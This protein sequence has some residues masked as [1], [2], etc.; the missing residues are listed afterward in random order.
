MSINDQIYFSNDLGEPLDIKEEK[1]KEKWI[2]LLQTI[3]G[4]LCIGTIT[5]VVGISLF[6]GVFGVQSYISAQKLIDQSCSI[7]N[8]PNSEKII[9]KQKIPI[10]LNYVTIYNGLITPEFFK[11]QQSIY[12]EKG[13]I[14]CIGN[15]PLTNC[16]MSP[17]RKEY[18]LKNAVITP[19]LVDIHSHFGVYSYPGDLR[20]YQD[21][22]E[23]GADPTTPYVRVI[24]A[25][26]STDEAIKEILSGGVTS[27]V[28]L[29]GSGN[30]IGGEG[31]AVKLRGK[32]VEEMRIKNS[33]RYL[34]FACGE[35][36]K[37][38]YGSQSKM[39]TTRMGN[40]W[41]M[42]KK[43]EAARKLLKEQNEWDCSKGEKPTN[44][45][46]EPLVALLKGEALLHNHC[47]EVVDFE[48]AIRVAKEFGYKITTF[49]HALEAHKIPK[50][51]KENNIS[52]ATFAGKKINLK[53]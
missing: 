13:V 41:V 11:K 27:S 7:Q 4:L 40:A 26:R 2:T 17:D 3:F 15:T 37:R 22:N 43:F 38:V 47:Y 12:F 29:P 28:V 24:D 19:G 20:A 34:K 14:K 53:F 48:M 36:P 45:E 6:S 52:I 39:P 21:G 51:F 50:T 49:H 42:R 16:K 35:N 9:Y 31:L 5:A 44:L 23:M 33:P 8:K 25:L 46:L 1:Q 10:L 18:D 30:V 32:T